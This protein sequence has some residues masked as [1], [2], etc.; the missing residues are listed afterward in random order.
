MYQYRGGSL[1]MDGSLYVNGGITNNGTY[2]GNNGA[3]FNGNIQSLGATVTGAFNQGSSSQFALDGSGNITAAGNVTFQGLATGN[4]GGLTNLPD[5]SLSNFRSGST[6]L[7]TAT[8]TVVLF[9]SALA[10]TNYAL[11][12]GFESTSV[13]YSVG[14]RTVNGFT[15]TTALYTG[16]VD[17]QA[18]EKR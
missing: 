4:G 7:T 16:S 18:A 8:S 9:S 11:T 17:Y 10:D 13:A 6:N 2:V 3:T 14:T 1:A 15:L 5:A 12:I